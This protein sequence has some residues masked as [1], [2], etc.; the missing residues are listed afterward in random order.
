MTVNDLSLTGAYITVDEIPLSEFMLSF[1]VETENMEPC[2]PW[3]MKSNYM[4]NLD[5]GHNL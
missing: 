5:V 2:Q 1:E 4:N 3:F